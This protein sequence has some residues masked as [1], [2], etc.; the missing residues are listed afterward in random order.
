MEIPRELEGTEFDWFAVDEHGRFALFATAGFGPIPKSVLSAAASH[1]AIGIG[2]AVTGW[3]S[4]DVWQSYSRAGLFAYNWS[5]LKGCY[6]RVAEPDAPLT[7]ELE[8][9]LAACPGIPRLEVSFSQTAAIEPPW[10]D[11]T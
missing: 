1:N 8:A 6:V 3:G 4:N 2:L 11:G 5:A 10:Q 7:R 9:R